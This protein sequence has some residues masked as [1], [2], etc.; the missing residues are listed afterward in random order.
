MKEL[1]LIL[2]ALICFNSCYFMVAMSQSVK[3]L[4]EAYNSFREI[5][6]LLKESN[7]KLDKI[8]GNL[9]EAN[10]IARKMAG[11]VEAVLAKCQDQEPAPRSP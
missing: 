1:T 8:H 4:V 10:L 3:G 5:K 2:V 11:R 9:K 7:N 6:D